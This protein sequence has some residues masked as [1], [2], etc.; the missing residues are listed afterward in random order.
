MND[1]I[2]KLSRV[3]NA[4]ID[5]VFDAWLDPQLLSRFM[6]PMP[7]MPQPKTE[8]DGREGGRFTIYMDIGEKIIPHSGTYLE[9]DRPNRLIFS[10]ESPFSTDGSTVTL[11]FTVQDKVKTRLE[12]THVRFIDEETRDNHEIG[13][14]NI[15]AALD[16]LS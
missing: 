12:L 15:L 9:L 6:L 4:P 10:W 14:S 11:E 16:E 5:K 13:W 7:G 3:I 8:V 1:L 2:C